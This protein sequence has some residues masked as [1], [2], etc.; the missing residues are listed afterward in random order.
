MAENNNQLVG[1]LPKAPHPKLKTL[2][3]LIGRWKISG[4]DVEGEVTYEWMEGGFFL[5]QKYDLYQGG[6]HEK[7][8]EYTGFDEET[9]TLRSRLMGTNGSRFTYTYEIDG[10]N[11]YYWFGDK[12][13]DIYS[14][15]TIGGDGSSYSG[16]WHWTNEDGTPGGYEF[17]VTRIEE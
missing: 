2:E 10:D 13:S 14:K 1:N 3:P 8:I 16:A 17:T 4:P 11:F 6:S 7:G 12:G 15:S 9:G 5:I